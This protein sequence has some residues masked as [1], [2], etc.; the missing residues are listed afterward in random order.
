[1]K[2]LFLPFVLVI[3]LVTVYLSGCSLYQN[4]KFELKSGDTLPSSVGFFNASK[5]AESKTGDV[6]TKHKVVF[7][8]DSTNDECIRR[9]DCISKM[10]DLI[11]CEGIQFLIVWEDT[12]PSEMIK[13]AGIDQSYNYSLK[14]KVSLSESKPT[15]YLTDENNKIMMVTGYSYISLINKI[16]ELGGKKDISNKAADMILKNVSKSG[17]FSRED[18]EKTLLMFL[19]SSCRRCKEYDEIV[20][21]N[22]DSMQKKIKIITVRPDFDEKQDYDK[23]FEIDPQQ[24]YFNI[25]A[26]SRDVGANDRKYPMFYILNS[27]NS[28]ER[29]F[30]DANEAVSYIL[31][32]ER[33]ANRNTYDKVSAVYFYSPTCA[34]CAGVSDFLDRF[35]KSHKNFELK[36]LD[37]SDL[38]NKSLLDKYSEAY[39][40][41]LED[42]GI[43]PV[44]FV[45]DKYFPDEESIRNNLETVIKN[46]GA[47]T[48]EIDSS[49]ENHEKDLSRFEGFRAAGIFLAGV[50][51]GVNPCSMSMLLF[52]LSLLTV[53]NIKILKIGFSFIIGKFLAYVLFGTILFKF[54]SAINFSFLNLFM[55]VLLAIVLLILIIMNIQDFF[56]AKGEKYEKIRMQLPKGFRRINHKIIKKTSEFSN[57][58]IILFISFI[59]G[60]IIS[61]GEFLCTGQI[62]LATIITIFQT[63]S[64]LSF[65][66]LGYLILYNFALIL[67][68]L[69]LTLL[70]YKGKEVFEV[71]EVIRERLHLIKMINA[72]ILIVFGVIIFL[73]L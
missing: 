30:T 56:A 67:P 14:G 62:Y 61:I 52:F 2:K 29:L 16:I 46:P 39:K 9:L 53:K 51:N 28:I 71:S 65:Q 8:L 24:I 11:G 55:K 42:E 38:R 54:L 35:S 6:K 40:V 10:I 4:K 7:Y 26:W 68:L 1:M 63:Y 49:L 58:N 19:T 12:I 44:V 33:K 18:N 41:S 43:V 22:I 17:G 73:F 37:I 69:I 47:K 66:A 70:V 60:I 21:K 48:L 32:L 72:L 20:R 45:R 59:L 50:V 23:Y 64:Q 5:G 34:S 13:E 27:D 36:K 15:A 31:G 3:V 57:S 25:F